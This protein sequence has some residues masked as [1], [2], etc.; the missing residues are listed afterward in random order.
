MHQRAAG[1]VERA[2][3]VVGGGRVVG[4]AKPKNPL[5]LFP[6]LMMNMDR[7]KE[8]MGKMMMMVMFA[9]VG[10]SQN[11]TCPCQSPNLR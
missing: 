11:L 9:W 7:V 5:M 4:G 10:G 3:A 6:V 1:K 2:V 8:M